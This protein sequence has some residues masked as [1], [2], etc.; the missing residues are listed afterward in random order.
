VLSSH[1]RPLAC[2]HSPHSLAT[3]EALRRGLAGLECYPAAYGTPGAMMA[4]VTL[5][6]ATRSSE[7]DAINIFRLGALYRPV[8]RHK[9]F[10]LLVHTT[11][12]W[13]LN[14]LVWYT[15]LMALWTGEHDAINAFRPPSDFTLHHTVTP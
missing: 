12:V 9:L 6:M 3:V 11:V 7:D 4:I 13:H 14:N 1:S 10:F 2:T 5:G 15:L 8:V